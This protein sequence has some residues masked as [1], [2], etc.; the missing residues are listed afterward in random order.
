MSSVSSSGQKESKK[1]LEQEL[2]L[3]RRVV[4]DY[5]AWRARGISA[6][7]RRFGGREPKLEQLTGTKTRSTTSSRAAPTY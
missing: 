2:E 6:D 7:G 1:R 3:E 5:Q 4:A